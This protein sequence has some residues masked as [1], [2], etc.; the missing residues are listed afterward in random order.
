MTQERQINEQELAVATIYARAALRLAEKQGTADE[1]LEEVFGVAKIL[2]E[3]P[4]VERHLLTP[5]VDE[6]TR[7]AFLEKILRGRVSDLLVDTLQVMNRKG[8]AG[9]LRAF[10]EAYRIELDR[11]RGRIDV[12]VKTAVPLNDDLRKMIADV[13]AFY[14]REETGGAENGPDKKA[15]LIEQVDEQLLGGF[16]LRMG[17]RKVDCSVA[18]E[19]RRVAEMFHERGS[20]DI[21]DGKYYLA[22]NT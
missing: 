22:E 11:L 3:H 7:R 12:N 5:L 9:L 1:M 15:R 4:E 2:G 16:V 19:L 8:R 21:Q 17:D 10:G 18:R 6:V 13:A 14:A 20:S